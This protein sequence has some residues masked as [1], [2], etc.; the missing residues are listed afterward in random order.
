M[1]VVDWILDEAKNK[2]KECHGREETEEEEGGCVLDT[3]LRL[4]EHRGE[5]Q[6]DACRHKMVSLLP[7]TWSLTVHAPLIK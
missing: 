2:I 1:E 4:S 5:C 3:V 7:F 6:R